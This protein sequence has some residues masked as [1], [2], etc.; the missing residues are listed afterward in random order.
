MNLEQFRRNELF[1]E[2]KVHSDL[3]AVGADFLQHPCYNLFPK[4]YT[5]KNLFNQKIQTNIFPQ[6]RFQIFQEVSNI[7]L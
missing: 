4:F 1:V 6:N 2:K 7:L 5:L 3:S